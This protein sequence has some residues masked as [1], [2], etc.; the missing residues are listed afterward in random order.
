MSTPSLPS[1]KIVKMIVTVADPIT[2]ATI[3]GITSAVGMITVVDQGLQDARP[4]PPTP[5]HTLVLVTT[6]VAAATVPIHL[7][8]LIT[9]TTPRIVIAIPAVATT[10]IRSA[11]DKPT[12]AASPPKSITSLPPSCNLFFP[13][14][15]VP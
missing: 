7:I 5:V 15:H 8:T 12:Q 3:H 1:P 9:H 2:T 11:A 6:I 13:L 10:M 14:S 4:L